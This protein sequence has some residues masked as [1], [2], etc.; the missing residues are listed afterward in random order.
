MDLMHKLLQQPQILFTGAACSKGSVNSQRSTLLCASR[1]S[2]AK[3]Y[4]LSAA[5]ASV[6]TPTAWR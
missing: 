5:G 1:P 4:F 2:Q 6:H 3:L